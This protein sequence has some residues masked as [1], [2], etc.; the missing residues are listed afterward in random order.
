MIHLEEIIEVPTDS[1]TA[2]A[3]VA[4]FT[5]SA[6][7]DPGV[8]H[9]HQLSGDGSG[10]GSRYQITA[11]FNGKERYLVYETEAHQPPD[12]VVFRGGDARFESVD[13]IT[14]QTV[15]TGTRITYAAD[16]RMKGLLVV[17]EPLLRG[18][19]QEVGE[20]AASGLAAALGGARLERAG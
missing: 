9:A 14:F 20:K 1:A 16:F 11:V 8:S 19:F 18:R 3:H 7:W 17:L 2:F 10:L 4:D 6:Q 13:T 12:R 5:T 15:E